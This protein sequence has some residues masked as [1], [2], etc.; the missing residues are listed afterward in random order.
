MK[1]IRNFDVLSSYV[2]I[3]KVYLSI[4]QYSLDRTFQ[5]ILNVK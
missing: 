1:I 3:L 2:G 4:I 5:R